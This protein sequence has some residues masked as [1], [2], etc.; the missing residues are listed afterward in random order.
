M[1]K[2]NRFVGILTLCLLLALL[3]GL[4]GVWPWAG[5]PL[6]V[7]FILWPKAAW[8]VTGGFYYLPVEPSTFALRS[9]QVF[10]VL[11]IGWTLYRYAFGA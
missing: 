6:G 7:A 4:A 2:K 9:R 10:G 1:E 8:I 11:L 3:R 5:F